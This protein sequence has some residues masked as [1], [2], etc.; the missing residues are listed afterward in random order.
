MRAVEVT[1][2]ID[3]TGTLSL[4]QPI[5]ITAPSR[6]RVI[7]LFEELQDELEEDNEPDDTSIEEIKIS[8]RR[9]LQETKAGQRIPFSEMWEEIDAQ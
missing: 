9:A 5:K 4:D 1:G 2:S 7:V 8:L 6:V 3:E